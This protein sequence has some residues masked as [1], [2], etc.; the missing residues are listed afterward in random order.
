M[1]SEYYFLPPTFEFATSM[2]IFLQK[3]GNIKLCGFAVLD[4]FSLGIL[5]ILISKYGIAVFSEPVGCGVL[6]S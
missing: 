3:E 2:K 6:S 5:V 4:N 1:I